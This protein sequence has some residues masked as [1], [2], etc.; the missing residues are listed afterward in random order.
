[1]LAHKD[2]ESNCKR[3]ARYVMKQASNPA[4]EE[5]SDMICLG[6]FLSRLVNPSLNGSMQK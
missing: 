3:I 2:F 1:M 4:S 5:F 6:K